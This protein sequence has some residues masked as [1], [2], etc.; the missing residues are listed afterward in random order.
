M[1]KIFNYYDG[2]IIFNTNSKYQA[3]NKLKEL[4]QEDYEHYLDY[5]QSNEDNHTYYADYIPTYFIRFQNK[6]GDYDFV[7]IINYFLLLR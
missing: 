4:E 5:K 7:N 3:I 2:C 6:D 1:Y